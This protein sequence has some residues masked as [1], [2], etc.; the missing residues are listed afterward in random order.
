[1]KAPKIRPDSRS[2]ALSRQLRSGASWLGGF[3]LVLNSASGQVVSVSISD[4][5]A[6]DTVSGVITVS[7]A[8]SGLMN[9][10]VAISVDG[11]PWRLAQGRDSWSFDWDTG[12]LGQGPHTLVARARECF[13]CTPAFDS[14]TVTVD[15]AGSGLQEFTY[16]S[17]VD[18]TPM[19]SKLWLPA[20]FD[21]N[22]PP[23]PIV[24]HLHGGGGL[25]SISGAMAAELDAR[26]WIGIA[27]D[28]REWGLAQLGC[29]WSNSSA[30]VNN[31]DPNVGP[32]EQD[33]FDAIEWIAALYP[34]DRDRIYL[35][36]FSMG[37]RGTYAIGL[38]NPDYFAAIAPMGAPT[39]MFEVHVRRPQNEECK[40]GMVGGVPGST[41]RVDTMV[42]VTSGRF[43][44]EN[45]FNIPVHHAHGLNDTVASNTTSESEYLHGWHVT[46]DAS[47]DACHGTSTFCFGHTPTLTELHAN[48]PDGYDWAYLFT[49]VG[50]FSDNRWLSGT[51]AQA[52][53]FGTA[54]PLNPGD[55]L[56]VYDFFERR[57]LVHSP[58]KIVFKT[59]EDEH[60]RA[61]WAELLTSAP[62]SAEP[63][64][65]RVTRDAAANA[66]HAE[67]ARAGEIGFDLDRAGLALTAQS[68]LSVVLAPLA[69]SAYDP[70]LDVTAE[71][72]TPRVRLE[73]GPDVVGAT[74]VLDGLV[75]APDMVSVSSGDVAIGPVDLQASTRILDV[76]A[77]E[78]FCTSTPN[79]TGLG[80][81]LRSSGTTSIGRNDFVLSVDQAIPNGAGLFFYGFAEADAPLGDG[82]LCIGGTLQ[83]APAPTFFD[84]TGSGTWD[85]DLAAPP[86][87]SGPNAITA[88]ATVRFQ[89][90][91]RDVGSPAGS[92]ASNALRARFL[93]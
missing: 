51:P 86:A 5:V 72:S 65:V 7:G 85:V 79:T 43:L 93:P 49:P 19:D 45:A 89:L 39:D 32:G 46:T 63:A 31:P 22:G 73:V 4:P 69:D 90:W 28:G 92:N 24:C 2:Q 6:G 37:G 14:V 21:P 54:D 88:G 40:N 58:E 56:G 25:G 74:A 57:T 83:R 34:V 9:G 87:S 80:A 71:S 76:Y 13:T 66:L 44:L 30:Y 16:F 48:E 15:G 36:G 61:F 62:W 77:V 18:G 29:D 68:P 8:S 53:L 52:G 27:P 12:P 26:G 42:K 35:T 60:R 23:V 64:A 3:L 84:G 59:Y 1:M 17:S 10:R 67:V 11:G 20:G 41:P 70:A 82:R 91:Y 75:L 33:I 38:K 81:R 78:A 47:F 55:L 50:H